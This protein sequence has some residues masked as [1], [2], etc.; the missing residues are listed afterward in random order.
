MGNFFFRKV[1]MRNITWKL[2]FITFILQYAMSLP[3]FQ[4]IKKR[5]V[6]LRNN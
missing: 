5:P 6:F 3:H 1:F 2:S 4:Q